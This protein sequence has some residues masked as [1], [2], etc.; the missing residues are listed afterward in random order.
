MFLFYFTGDIYKGVIIQCDKLLNKWEQYQSE[1]ENERYL[2]SD[3]Y[4]ISQ[5]ETIIDNYE[6]DLQ[7][8]KSDLKNEKEY[9]TYNSKIEIKKLESDIEYMNKTLDSLKTE[10]QKLN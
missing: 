2:Q 8:K 10:L 6:F 5:L 7:M 9:P 4:K 3:E 1:L